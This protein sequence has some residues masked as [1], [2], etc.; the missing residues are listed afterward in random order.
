[1]SERLTHLVVTHDLVDRGELPSLLEGAA[2]ST[3]TESYIVNLTL[4]EPEI[5]LYSPQTLVGDWHGKTLSGR[6]FGPD[7]E[8]KWQQNKGRLFD[9]WTLKESDGPTNDEEFNNLNAKE[10]KYYCIGIWKPRS[11]CFSDGRLPQQLLYPVNGTCDTDRF[12][13]RAVAYR[14]SKTISEVDLEKIMNALNRPRIVAYRLTG[15][16]VDSGTPGL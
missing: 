6:L 10:L 15:S 1:M 11:G 12:F 9:V 4:D 5:N 14:P 3:G 2:K 13:F 8:F 16:S 7:S